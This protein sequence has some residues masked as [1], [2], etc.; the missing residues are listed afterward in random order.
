MVDDAGLD[1]FAILAV[2]QGGPVA[3]EYAD[4][5]PERVARLACYGSYAGAQVDASPEELDLD[6][7]FT[8]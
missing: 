5:H 3:V 6:A 4:R 2:A 1:R 7:A 8:A